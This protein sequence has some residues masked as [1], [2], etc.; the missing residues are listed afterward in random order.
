MKKGRIILLGF[1]LLLVLGLAMGASAAR[2]NLVLY[3]DRDSV[4][5]GQPIT[6][7]VSVDG[8]TEVALDNLWFSYGYEDEDG[9]IDYK[10]NTG[11]GAFHEE[12]LPMKGSFIPKFGQIGHI[13]ARVSHGSLNNKQFVSKSAMV[14]ITGDT[15]K[16]IEVIWTLNKTTAKPGDTI[17]YSFKITGG[18]NARLESLETSSQNVHAV[19]YFGLDMA[20]QKGSFALRNYEGIQRF[21]I[22]IVDDLGQKMDATAPTIDVSYKE[23]KNQGG[24]WYLYEDGKMLTGFQRVGYTTYYLNPQGVLQ[25]GWF[26]IGKDWYYSD[27]QGRLNTQNNPYINGKYY[28]FD[29]ETYAMIIGWRKLDW[30]D[31]VVQWAYYGADGAEVSNE[32]IPAGDQWFYMNGW[33]MA[34]GNQVING[35][36]HA[37]SDSGVWQGTF[38]PQDGWFKETDGNWYYFQGGVMKT[39]W[40]MLD[41]Q[42]YYFNFNEKYPQ[43]N[44][45]LVTGWRTL[46]DAKYYFNDD[47][48]MATGWVNDDGTWF[49]LGSDGVMQTGWLN[50]G[51]SWYYLRPESGRI[52]KTAWVQIGGSW[53]YFN[54]NG[55]MQTGWLQLGDTWY[56]LAGSGAMVTGTHTIGGVSYSF[57]GGGAWLGY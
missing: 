16:P 9:W 21:T 29:D 40:A 18:V 31:D 7:M 13:E 26:T 46:G 34:R 50:S 45:Y 32:W 25:K 24:N 54:G 53:Y 11:Y 33:L 15:A 51:G 20:S 8:G 6:A 36:V 27:D 44:G 12:K 10:H 38:T 19:E 43:Y 22:A 1:V 35:A 30:D 39:G 37:F 52:A 2:P 41:G 48:A 56:Y 49:Y 14:Q 5:I 4:Q 55:I 28:G 42:W 57:G 23:W 47:G 3:L 17:N